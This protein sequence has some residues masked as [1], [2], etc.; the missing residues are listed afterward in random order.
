MDAQFQPGL[1]R[2][3]NNNSSIW[4]RW[5]DDVF[6]LSN[7]LSLKKARGETACQFS[8]HQYWHVNNDLSCMESASTKTQEDTK[9]SIHILAFKIEVGKISVFLKQVSLQ[10][11]IYLILQNI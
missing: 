3:S 8:F 1:R 5:S 4:D 2:A 11:C 10:S 7:I 6:L 9:C